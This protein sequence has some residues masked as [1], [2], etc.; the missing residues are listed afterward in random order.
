M[1]AAFSDLKPALADLSLSKRFVLVHASPTIDANS[2]LESLLATTCGFITPTFT[3][4]TL[5]PFDYHPATSSADAA[6]SAEIFSSSAPTD[7]ALGAFPELVR[8]H[9]KAKRSAHPVFSFA[10][11]DADFALNTQ[12]LFDVYAPIAAL[13]QEEGVVLLVG[14]DQRVNFSVHYGE[15][16]AG[17]TQFVRWARAESGIVEC[18]NF[19]GDSEGFN[20]VALSL[21]PFTR[22]AEVGG[23][24]I[25]A[26]PL[27][28]LL[29]T[30]VNKIHEDAYSLLCARP[31]CERCEAVRWG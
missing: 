24:I 6:L 10:G 19:P 1:P 18:P 8:Q 27:K 4:K 30:V 22:Q 31:D 29:R 15:K 21:R 17:R 2:L 28:D 3:P 25:Q 26:I 11:L 7:E 12:T 9:V 16:L 14:L 20:A 5:L 23:V 13:A